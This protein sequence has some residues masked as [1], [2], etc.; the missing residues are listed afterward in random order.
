MN[1]KEIGQRMRV[2]RIRSDKS[3]AEV[4]K[5]LGLSG[6]SYHLLETGKTS[7][8]V[9]RMLELCNLY[10]I[11]P[12]SFFSDPPPASEADME[13]VYKHV[14][15]I[16]GPAFDTKV[17]RMLELFNL[18]GIPPESFLKNLFLSSMAWIG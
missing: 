9:T 13:E 14:G 16:V 5:A 18:Y 17:T 15:P 6:P 1:N 3:Q 4:A 10:G 2:L 12:E 11:P 7:L 8:K